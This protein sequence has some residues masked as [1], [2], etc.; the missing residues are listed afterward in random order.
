MVDINFFDMKKYKTIVYVDGFNLYYGVLK[1]TSYKWLNF[2]ALVK[3]L[4]TKNEII[5][6][7]YFT[8]HVTDVLRRKN[9]T[10]YINALYKTIPY[11][12]C[13]YGY[14]REKN[15]TIRHLNP[16][17]DIVHGIA[18]EEKCTDVNIAVEIVNDCH[19][20]AF[21]CVVLISNDSDLERAI[22]IAKKT[23]KKIVLITPKH[24]NSKCKTAVQL[25]RHA[26]HH[27]KYLNTNVLAKSLLPNKVG[28][29]FCPKNW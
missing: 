11:F 25:S 26:D 27:L 28:N 13:I 17:P 10:T 9:Q 18:S 19:T 22:G 16:P 1:N 21:D 14:F 8:A 15:V 29:S 7:K 5:C 20:L 2:D 4:L 6:L 23:G 12:E 3:N 24:K